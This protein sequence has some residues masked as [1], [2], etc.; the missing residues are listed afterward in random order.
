[1]TIKSDQTVE[2]GD[3]T[4]YNASLSLSSQASRV[5]DVNMQNWEKIRHEIKP[6]I[7]YS[8]VPNVS[9]NNIP[10]Y[11]LP[12]LSPFIMPGT[13]PIT[14]HPVNL[15]YCRH[16]TTSSYGLEDKTPLP[17]HLQTLLRPK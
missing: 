17:G 16:V 11:Y 14:L 2:R 15:R 4:I 9:Q 8:Y 13:T 10:D 5:F 6:E 12:A 1:M 3:R 7:I